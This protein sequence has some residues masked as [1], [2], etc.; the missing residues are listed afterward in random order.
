VS[1]LFPIKIRIA[2]Q[3][4]QRTAWLFR[5]GYFSI[6]KPNAEHNFIQSLHQESA[7]TS[8]ETFRAKIQS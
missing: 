6:A 3:V 2:F 4:E 5:T 1:S 7:K 8:I